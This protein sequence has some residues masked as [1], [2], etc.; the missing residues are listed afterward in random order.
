MA[1]PAEKFVN[2]LESRGLVEPKVIASLRQLTGPSGL[3]SSAQS[4]ANLLTEQQLLTEF[5]ANRLLEEA[6]QTASETAQQ[7]A[8][9]QAP[10]ASS[11]NSSI[12]RSTPSAGLSD[13]DLDLK[14][15]DNDPHAAPPLTPV[16][17][18]EEAPADSG[19]LDLVPLSDD[20]PNP[21]RPPVAKQ[22]IQQK[23]ASGERPVQRTRQVPAAESE[24]STPEPSQ[25]TPAASHRQSS[26]NQHVE[27]LLPDDASIGTALRPVKRKRG[28]R[29][30]TSQWESPLILLG[31]GMLL[32]LILAV[33]FFYWILTRETA[34][35]LFLLAEK[36]YQSQSYAQ[37]IDKYTQFISRFPSDVNISKARVRISLSKLRQA[38]E[39]TTDWERAMTVAKQELQIIEEEEQFADTARPELA[40]LLPDIA[41]G[42]AN[43]ARLA[44][45]T[46][47]KQKYVSLYEEA[48]QLVDNSVYLPSSQRAGQQARILQIKEVV[49]TIRRD[50][51]RDKEL[52]KTV[53]LIN[54]YADEGNTPEAYAARR[55]LLQTYPRLEKDKRLREGILEISKKERENVRVEEQEQ[56]AMT[57]EHPSPVKA[58]VALGNRTGQ[59][60]RGVSQ[61]VL[62]V[63][64]EGSVYGL[65]ASTGGL[66][67]RRFVGHETNVH[68]AAV[69]GTAGA[70]A[71]LV[72][73]HRHELVRVDAASGKLRWRL[74]IGEPTTAPLI[75]S[76]TIIL[77]TRSG[78]VLQVDPANGNSFRHAVLPQPV[79]VAPTKDSRQPVLY[80]V[81]DHSNLY[82]L[83][84]DSLECQTVHYLGHE[85]ATVA[86]PPAST[87]GIIFVAENSGINH[88][89]LHILSTSENG[90]VISRRQDPIRLTDHVLAPLLVDGR[91]VVV[92]TSRGAVYL[93]EVDS[94][95]GDSP[96]TV[97][98]NTSP[99]RTE[100]ISGF[101]VTG[102]SNLWLGDTQLTGFSMRSSRGS[103][104]RR[105]VSHEGETFVGPIQTFGKLLFHSRRRKRT[106][107]TIVSAIQ[108]EALSI[109]GRSP[110]IW[111]TRLGVPPA[112]NVTIDE[113]KAIY[114]VS[115][116]GT[117]FRIQK[118]QLQASVTDQPTGQV[119]PEPQTAFTKR[120]EMA[121]GKVVFISDS[122]HR[123]ILLF[124]PDQDEKAL[125]IVDLAVDETALRAT[126][127]VFG[128][129]VLVP[130]GNGQIHYL[131]VETGNRLMHPF[132]PTLGP[133]ESV[134]WRRPATV[135]GDPPQFVATDGQRKV[136]RVGIKEKP[137]H[138]AAFAEVDVNVAIQGALAVAGDTVYGVDRR[139]NR[140]VVI[141]F[142]LSDLAQGKTE[143]ELE[144][145]TEWGPEM[146]GDMVLVGDQNSLHCFQPGQTRRWKKPLAYGPI[147]GTPLAFGEHL[148]LASM[149]GVV[150][151]INAE[152]GELLG[153]ID[154]GEPLASGPAQFDSSILLLT[155]YDGTLYAFPAP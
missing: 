50:I 85:E 114:S 108:L 36:D 147:T 94:S 134:D 7:S 126:T 62:F 65:R 2:L 26:E 86:V 101:A 120:L 59:T 10:Q 14:P 75:L 112:G 131:N 139:E 1:N 87:L 44:Q 150:W 97:I 57:E 144:G 55:D 89:L 32:L 41:D 67:W 124:A 6:Q 30:I 25:S 151:W 104:A 66:L 109:S 137:R 51:N 12:G 103:I 154:V 145:R 142:Q 72:D 141:S 70:D 18:T 111:Q 69:S 38:T 143:W 48:M 24:T 29:L 91:T 33:I 127:Q 49:E 63:L 76:Q 8:T 78:R 148:V 4:I 73:G 132:Q 35:E 90:R 64:A 130:H 83:S 106:P 37:A 53:T 84:E 28:I 16:K 58:R 105:S 140:D 152:T 116:D 149:K 19:E 79:R 40:S 43:Q 15:L 45:A 123:Q 99:T 20:Q 110:P 39:G 56:N 9:D 81:A 21:D 115:A 133:G 34:D 74:P 80:V 113:N 155:G 47:Q 95:D 71:V 96:V 125:K 13:D 82:S 54:Q 23:P 122:N 17:P 128:N 102:D 52:L 119:N 138:L 77:A 88:S 153:N 3:Q 46:E 92:T 5:Q 118:E 11:S 93:L 42:F 60:A 136:F 68:P 135:P 129:G 121:N 31:S 61:H 27:S 98:A 117:Y 146:V 22:E 107:G 100:S